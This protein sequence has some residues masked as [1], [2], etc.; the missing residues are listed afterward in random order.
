VLRPLHQ[1]G[2]QIGIAFL[3]DMHLRFALA[4]VPASRLQSQIATHV[5]ALAEAVLICQR[6]QES[7]PQVALLK[8]IKGV[9]T[10]IALTSGTITNSRTATVR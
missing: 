1:Q 8:Q 5:A 4:G 7:Y 10:L 3:A 6:Q 9:G 2:S